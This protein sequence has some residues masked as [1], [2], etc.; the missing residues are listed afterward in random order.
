MRSENAIL[1][2]SILDPELRQEQYRGSV[3]GRL[4]NRPRN[5]EL[6]LQCILR[7]YFGDDGLPPV[8]GRQQFER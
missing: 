2:R 5:L 3:P 1:Q 8:F 6:G 4:A 7:E